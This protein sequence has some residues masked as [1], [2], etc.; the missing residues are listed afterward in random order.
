MK[1]IEG[2]TR[3]IGAQKR[4]LI[5]KFSDDKDINNVLSRKKM[6]IKNSLISCLLR[7]IVEP[8]G[9]TATLRICAH[10]LK[11]Y[12]TKNFGQKSLTAMIILPRTIFPY[13]ETSLLVQKTFKARPGS[14]EFF[15]SEF[16]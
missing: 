16:K 14:H 9:E 4:A 12:G 1:M 5:I 10:G 7:K 13:F 15:R 2:K 6:R 11:W 3:G 8:R